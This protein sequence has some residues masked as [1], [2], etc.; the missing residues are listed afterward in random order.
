MIQTLLKRMTAMMDLL[1]LS[2]RYWIIST[3]AA[4][5]LP[6]KNMK[7]MFEKTLLFLMSMWYTNDPPTKRRK[8]VSFQSSKQTA[9]KERNHQTA[10]RKRSHFLANDSKSSREKKIF[11]LHDEI[12]TKTTYLLLRFSFYRQFA[13]V[14]VLHVNCITYIKKVSVEYTNLLD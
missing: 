10:K 8:R 3:M 13:F 12:A 2:R 4:M 5:K 7:K 11:T 9:K 14:H 1:V 6:W